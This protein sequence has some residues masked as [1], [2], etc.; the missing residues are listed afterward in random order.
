MDNKKGLL[1]EGWL[2]V[3]FTGVVVVQAVYQVMMVLLNEGQ[4]VVQLVTVVA[5]VCFALFYWI[6]G[7]GSLP[8]V[9]LFMAVHVFVAVW[10]PAGL[11]G[12]PFI[13]TVLLGF[14]FME[15]DRRKRYE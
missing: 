4:L 2:W 7:D 15:L 10:Q 11:V 6:K 12:T 3:L 14:L 5:F 1:T 13:T 9:W 8:F